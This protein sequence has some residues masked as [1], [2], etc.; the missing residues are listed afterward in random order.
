MQEFFIR[1]R[2]YAAL[3]NHTAMQKLTDPSNN[4]SLNHIALK[5]YSKKKEEAQQIEAI[6]EHLYNGYKQNK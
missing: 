2:V 1:S 6:P 5:V 4:I 3:L